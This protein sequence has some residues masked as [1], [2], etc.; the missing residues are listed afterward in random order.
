[1]KLCGGPCG[2]KKPLQD[3]A[4][5]DKKK[6]RRQS[7]CRECKGI[8]LKKHYRDNK[9]YYL[10][11][12]KARNKRITDENYARL[13]EYLRSHPCVDCGED[14]ML[15]LEFDHV[16][17]GTKIEAVTILVRDSYSWEAILAEIKKCEV[18]CANCHRRKTAKQF[19]WRRVLA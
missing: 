16:K 9:P 12:S 17:R 10:K 13:Y 14:D 1:M 11:K 2:Q 4:F 6:G 18:R 19:K 7:T 5:K 8:Y 15:V 3:F